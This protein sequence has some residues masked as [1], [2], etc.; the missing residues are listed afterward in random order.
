M[1][2]LIST[3]EQKGWVGSYEFAEYQIGNEHEARIFHKEHLRVPTAA[4]R[5]RKMSLCAE[6]LGFTPVLLPFSSL[7]VGFFPRTHV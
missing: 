6:A 4:V 7:K 5:D 1:G 2:L 3:S